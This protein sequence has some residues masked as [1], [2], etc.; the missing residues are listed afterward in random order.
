MNLMNGT[1]DWICGDKGFV[2]GQD[3]N[4]YHF[5][6]PAFNESKFK[7]GQKVW[8]SIVSEACPE[9]NHMIS[10]NMQTFEE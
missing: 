7:A 8:F 3:N 2:K 9:V 1:I 6:A 4:W 5:W 10:D